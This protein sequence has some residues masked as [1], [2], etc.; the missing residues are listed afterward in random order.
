MIILVHS[1][2]FTDLK[3]A[4]NDLPSGTSFPALEYFGENVLFS[5]MLDDK[6]LLM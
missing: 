6:Q 4:K 5:L 3:H 2:P 1:Q